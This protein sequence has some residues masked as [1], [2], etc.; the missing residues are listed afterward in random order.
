MEKVKWNVIKVK[1]IKIEQIRVDTEHAL[2][3]LNTIEQV[4]VK[5]QVHYENA[6][7]LLKQVKAKTKELDGKRKGITGPLDIAKKAVMD[8]FRIPLDNL[9]KAEALLKDGMITYSDKQDR[10]RKEQEA[11][12]QRQADADRRKKE[13][14]QRA[15][16]EK[17]RAKREEA[18]KL[19]KAGKQEEAI[20]AQAEAD[21]AAEKAEEREAEAS[22]IE[23]PVLAETATKPVGVS[24]REKW[25]AEVVDISKVPA[26]YLLP[27]MMML[28][29]VAVATKGK[30]VIAGVKFKSEK[31]LA[32]R[33]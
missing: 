25:T 5:N 14:Q 21:K 17:E 20:K 6:A 27:N 15:W 2:D 12:L 19:A 18:E 28:N 26:D 11:K 7:D 4:E 22:T 13:E 31:I 24:Y 10:I 3:M 9:A 33:S 16:E 23:A 30:L 29:K 1:P 32:S 8:L